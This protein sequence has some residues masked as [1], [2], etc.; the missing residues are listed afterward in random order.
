MRKRNQ[1]INKLIFLQMYI[2]LK[3][4]IFVDNEKS[5]DKIASAFFVMILFSFA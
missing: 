5:G 1:Q 4:A 3:F 2:I